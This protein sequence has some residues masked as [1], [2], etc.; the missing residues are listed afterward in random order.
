LAKVVVSLYNKALLR[1]LTHFPVFVI[2]GLVVQI[3][4]CQWS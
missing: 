3:R 2:A 1:F 4:F